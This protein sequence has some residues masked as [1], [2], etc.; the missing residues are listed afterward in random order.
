MSS[1]VIR[2]K[3]KSFQSLLAMMLSSEM[4]FHR[5][6]MRI[7]VVRRSSACIRGCFGPPLKQTVCDIQSIR[8][9]SVERYI[10][11]SERIDYHKCLLDLG[12]HD[13]QHASEVWSHPKIP[14]RTD[15]TDSYSTAN[16][17][18]RHREPSG[19]QTHRFFFRL[20][21]FRV[22]ALTHFVIFPQTTHL[23]LGTFKWR[24]LCSRRLW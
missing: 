11:D 16:E 12:A 18:K 2:V 8:R 4:Y 7:L 23:F 19:T 9:A 17:L 21:W 24:S 14:C 20:T 22:W 1:V 3:E 15:D 5:I 10:L 6:Y 13:F